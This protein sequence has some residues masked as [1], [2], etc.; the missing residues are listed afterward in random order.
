MTPLM[1]LA[2]IAVLIA[3]AMNFNLVHSGIQM[4]SDN[5]T[6]PKTGEQLASDFLS[7][8][9]NNITLPLWLLIFIILLILIIK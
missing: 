4:M 8:I 9:K 7:Q 6:A 3:G 1:W 2:L 5:Q